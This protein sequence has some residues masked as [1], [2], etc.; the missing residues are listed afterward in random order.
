MQHIC[1]RLIMLSLQS[2]WKKVTFL[3][4]QVDNEAQ[5]ICYTAP[6]TTCTKHHVSCT[7]VTWGWRQHLS[8]TMFYKKGSV[9]ASMMNIWTHKWAIYVQRNIE[10]RLWNRCCSGKTINIT[11]SEC[12]CW[13]RYQH[14]L[15]MHHTVMWP[16]P[17]CNILPHYLINNLVWG[18]GAIQHKMCVSIFST[19][20]AW[21]ISQS[22]KNWVR[23]DKKCI[24][25]FM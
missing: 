13:L 9:L 4:E 25:V 3:C 8:E 14:A 5:S 15:H 1:K 7:T 19:T 17:L 20:C 12:V 21:N 2:G 6:E 24:S 23:C 22:K 11:Y 16:A 18:G 10:V